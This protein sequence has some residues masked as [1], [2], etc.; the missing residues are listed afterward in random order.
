MSHFLKILILKNLVLK[1]YWTIFQAKIAFNCLKLCGVSYVKNLLTALKS[2][3]VH[4]HVFR[5]KSQFF[6]F[7]H[8]SVVILIIKADCKLNDIQTSETEID[9]T[10]FINFLVKGDSESVRYNFWLIIL[11]K[12]DFHFNKFSFK[13]N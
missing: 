7:T 12:S 10:T 4:V 1:S 11:L 2:E 6:S 5:N 9:G 3:N 8:T 13:K